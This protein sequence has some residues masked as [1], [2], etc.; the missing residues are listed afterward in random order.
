MTDYTKLRELAQQA[1]P[2]PWEAMPRLR[3]QCAV[4]GDGNPIAWEQD[5]MHEGVFTDTDAE[6][7]AAANPTAVLAILDEL[8]DAKARAWDEGFARGH[9]EAD[10][11]TG[12]DGIELTPQDCDVHNPYRDESR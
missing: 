11:Y 1:T 8:R 4:W 3:G 5:D 7:I 6:F 12:L 9:K 2:G 10:S